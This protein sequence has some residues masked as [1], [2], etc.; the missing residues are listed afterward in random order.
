[1]LQPNQLEENMVVKIKP[2]LMGD[3]K[4][5][6]VKNVMSSFVVLKVSDGTTKSYHISDLIEITN[7][8]EYNKIDSKLKY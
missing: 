4:Y 1:M 7:S 6:R 8:D 5:G 3:Y 2:G